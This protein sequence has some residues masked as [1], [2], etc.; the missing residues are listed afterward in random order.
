MGL[1]VLSLLCKTK[2]DVEEVTSSSGTLADSGTSSERASDND[3]A[4]DYRTCGSARR[5]GRVEMGTDHITMTSLYL[6]D[7]LIVIREQRL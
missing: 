4:M 3:I 5:T 6:M 1:T 7:I 2:C